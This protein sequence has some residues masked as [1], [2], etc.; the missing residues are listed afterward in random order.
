VGVGAPNLTVTMRPGPQM[1]NSVFETVLGAVVV[2]AAGIFLF[3]ALNATG[4]GGSGQ[5]YTVTARF[6]SVIGIERGSDVRMSGV[7]IGRVSKLDFD[8]ERYEAVLKLSLRSDI[9]LRDD[10][11]AKI[12]QDGLLGGA[13]VALQPG[14]GFDVIAA[15][16]TGEITQTQGSVDLLTLFAQ[17]AGGQ[18]GN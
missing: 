9:Q 8:A 14:G 15:D 11:S 4:N 17:F 3:F 12:S 1:R 16:G 10:A 18:G 2:C 13:Y 7:K 6:N 5:E